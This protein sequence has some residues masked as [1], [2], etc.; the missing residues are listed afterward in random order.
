MLRT[1]SSPTDCLLFTAT[2]RIH[3]LRVITSTARTNSRSDAFEA[4]ISSIARLSEANISNINMVD[5]H[6]IVINYRNGMVFKMG[7]WN[8]AEYKLNM[9]ATVMNDPAVKGKKGFLTMIG[10]KRMRIQNYR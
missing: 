2:I 8:D 7:N 6:A 3:V 4:L 9:A 1:A 5:E 10:S